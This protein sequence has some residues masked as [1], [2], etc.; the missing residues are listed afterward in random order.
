MGS[1]GSKRTSWEAMQAGAEGHRAGWPG[2][3][4]RGSSQGSQ[5]PA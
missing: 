4:D 3:A 1:L 5:A 2:M